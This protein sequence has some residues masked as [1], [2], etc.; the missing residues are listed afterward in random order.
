[1]E[2][3]AGVLKEY[4]PEIIFCCDMDVHPDHLCTSLF[5]EEALGKVLREGRGYCP[6]VYKGFAYET[7][8]FA[9]NDFF[10]RGG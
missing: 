10:S 3:L 4:Y 7:A 5:F 8:Y 2:M 1:M 9:T 6:L